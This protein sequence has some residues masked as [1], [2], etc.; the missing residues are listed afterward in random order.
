M[1]SPLVTV[2]RGRGLL[3]AIVIKP[4]QIKVSPPFG[5][6]AQGSGSSNAHSDGTAGAPL[7]HTLVPLRHSTEVDTLIPPDCDGA[8]GAPLSHTLDPIEPHA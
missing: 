4:T 1:N 2:V 5:S 8:T 3:N 7:S 6:R